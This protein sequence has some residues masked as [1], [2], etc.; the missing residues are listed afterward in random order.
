[1]MRAERNRNDERRTLAGK[2][3][4][5]IDPP[6]SFTNSCTRAKP[7]PVPSWVRPREPSTR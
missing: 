3:S 1:M 5:R 2:A 7:I 4:A 6:W